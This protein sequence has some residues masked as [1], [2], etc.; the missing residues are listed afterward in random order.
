MVGT[1]LVLIVAVV[2]LVLRFDPEA[3]HSV[4]VEDASGG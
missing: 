3:R 1:L 2:G 4:E